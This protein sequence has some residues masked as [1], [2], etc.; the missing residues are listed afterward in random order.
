MDD[1]GIGYVRKEHADHL[2]YVLKKY[3]T[4]IQD[5]TGT[6]YT[7]INLAWNYK[8]RVRTFR[9]TINGYIQDVLRRYSHPTPKK[10]QMSPHK[11]HPIVFGAKTQYATEDEHS[12][13]LDAKGVRRVQGI[14]SSLLYIARAVNNKLLVGLSAIG[15]QQANTTEAT[16]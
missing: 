1:F 11:H 6:K 12:P 4:I 10:L 9:L 13:P 5:W 14:V 3:H 2:A 8:S 16:S 15:A 7:G